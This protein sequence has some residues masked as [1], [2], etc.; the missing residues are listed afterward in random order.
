MPRKQD[1]E[2]VDD[3]CQRLGMSAQERQ[4]F[5]RYLHLLK[6]EGSGSSR[7]A[8]SDFTWPELLNESKNFLR[9]MR[10]RRWLGIPLTTTRQRCCRV[11]RV[12]LSLWSMRLMEMNW[13]SDSADSHDSDEGRAASAIRLDVS[14]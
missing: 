7:N 4:Q 8:R 2:Q 10:G 1:I 5:G 12:S 6:K 13:L 9:D 11:L 3:V 14:I